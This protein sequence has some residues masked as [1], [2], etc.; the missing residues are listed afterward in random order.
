MTTKIKIRQKG[1]V[2]E[3]L[4]LVQ[5]PMETG[6]RK[7]SKT[8]EVIPA[9]FIQTMTFEHNG[10]AVADINLG[11]SVSKNPLIGIHVKGTKAGDTIKVSWKD[12]KGETG[13]TESKVG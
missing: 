3:V 11:A 6:T 12:N 2:A 9:H 10:K 13:G 1:D 5:H 7:D 4:T 8:K